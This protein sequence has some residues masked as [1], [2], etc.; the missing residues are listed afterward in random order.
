MTEQPTKTAT[1]ANAKDAAVATIV[2]TAVAVKDYVAQSAG[3]AKDFVAEKA[4]HGKD[5]I[6]EKAIHGKD[7]AIEKALVIKDVVVENAIASKDFLAEKAAVGK[8][9]VV[10]KAGV[11]KEHAGVAWQGVKERTTGSKDI[12]ANTA[13]Q[14][15]SQAGVEANHD[16]GGVGPSAY[17]TMVANAERAKAQDAKDTHRP[18]QTQPQ[19][20]TMVREMAARDASQM[21]GVVKENTLDASKEQRVPQ[22]STQPPKEGG[23]A[24]NV[25][26]GATAQQVAKEPGQQSNK[27]STPLTDVAKATISDN[28]PASN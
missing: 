16:K 22:M 20:D 13:Y 3:A 26:A 28:Q 19:Q 9:F 7:L 4:T 17:E 24:P 27:S 18:T 10:D 14:S 11:A 15:R 6:V 12:L 2:E 1:A 23:V 8:D 25:L 5:V 21:S